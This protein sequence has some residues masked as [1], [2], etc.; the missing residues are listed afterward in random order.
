MLASIGSAG[1]GWDYIISYISKFQLFRP[2]FVPFDTDRELT[3][4]IDL[5]IANHVHL[6]EPH[7][8]PMAE[9]QAVDRVHRIGQKREVMVTRYIVSNTI[10]TV[11]LYYRSR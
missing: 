1:E 11:C 6:V 3:S 2:S 4:R 8:S 7:W 10:E 5:T 9:A